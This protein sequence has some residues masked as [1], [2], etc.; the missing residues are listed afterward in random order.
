MTDHVTI[1]DQAG[2]RCI[3][4]R[5]FEKKNAMTQPMYASM[6]AALDSASADDAIRSVVICGIPGAFCAGNDLQ[7]FLSEVESGA[8]IAAA[9][10]FLR[11]LARC[12]K[13][14]VA[15]V[16]GLAV[17]VGTTML[18]HCDHVVASPA[19][20]FSTPFTQLGVVPEAASSLL[21]PRLMGHQ[22]AFSLLVLG[23]PMDAATALAC[24]LVSTVADDVAAASTAV[25]REI[26]GLPAEAVKLS[27]RLLRGEPEDIIKRMNDEAA[28]FAQLMRSP[29]A[30]AAFNAFLSRK[31]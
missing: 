1:A 16:D 28:L 11:A 14:L 4:M 30:L 8:G 2:L 7:D 27:R 3:A 21:A 24:G 20:R 9:M 19:A 10:S 29:E 31:K 18:F 12:D 22:R 13:P 26:S 6:A 5:R 17:G 25:A 23:R 15:A